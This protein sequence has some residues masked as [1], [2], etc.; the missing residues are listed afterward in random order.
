MSQLGTASLSLWKRSFGGQL[1]ADS[2]NS[3]DSLQGLEGEPLSGLREATEYFLANRDASEYLT[4]MFLVGGP[5]AGKSSIAKGLVSNLREID[6]SRTSLAARTHK[7]LGK[8]R[9]LVLINDATMSDESA[10]VSL[11]TDIRRCL[12]SSADL[13]ACINRGV[14]VEES[15]HPAELSEL[16]P[17]LEFAAGQKTPGDVNLIVTKDQGTWKVGELK[18]GGKRVVLVAAYLDSTSLL[19]PNS[20]ATAEEKATNFPGVELLRGL[21][22]RVHDEILSNQIPEPV[23]SNIQNLQDEDIFESYVKILSSAEIAN[24]SFFNWRTLWGVASRVVFAGLPGAFPPENP[25]AELSDDLEAADFKR[26]R[27]LSVIR[28]HQAIFGAREGETSLFSGGLSVQTRI[29]ERVDPL[30]SSLVDRVSSIDTGEEVGA[31]LTTVTDAFF[32]VEERVSPLES[33][34]RSLTTDDHFI[35]YVT[36]FDRMLDVRF[37]EQLDATPAGADRQYLISWYA[38]Y[39]IR[40]Y[41]FANGHIGNQ[42]VVSLLAEIIQFEIIPDRQDLVR[43]ILALLR[44][45]RYAG[46]TD[47]AALLSLLDSRVSPILGDLREPKLAIKAADLNVSVKKRGS[48]LVLQLTEH[49]KSVGEVNLDFELIHEALAWLPGY[50]GITESASSVIPRMERLRATRLTPNNLKSSSN[51]IVVALETSDRQLKLKVESES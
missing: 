12:E 21:F 15:A 37:M 44:P 51:S 20:S 28:C 32:S 40:A 8:N 30:R 18:F 49:G 5:G 17:I 1:V 25:F 42:V 50:A 24:G 48:D 6:P 27:E 23:R 16:D 45:R 3:S 26:L 29:F 4:F 11:R 43:R 31:W 35:K 38:Q 47:G 13:I 46:E 41:A 36:D 10:E 39:L 14:F 7:Y 9:Q 34:L 22:R 33:L 19:R 2:P